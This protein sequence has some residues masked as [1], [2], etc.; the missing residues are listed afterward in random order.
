MSFALNESQQLS[1]FNKLA[2]LSIKKTAD[3]GAILGSSLFR[4][5]NSTGT[6]SA[7]ADR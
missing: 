7:K 2:S 1:L 6:V 5:E 4:P 3:A